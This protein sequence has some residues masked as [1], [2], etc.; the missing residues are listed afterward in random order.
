MVEY[1]PGKSTLELLVEICREECL[2]LV[3]S[4]HNSRDNLQI[5]SLL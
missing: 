3:V 4:L 1:T 5:R 2:T